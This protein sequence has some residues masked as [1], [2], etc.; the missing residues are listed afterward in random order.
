MNTYGI[1]EGNK[2]KVGKIKT[3]VDFN[4][5]PYWTFCIT[6]SKEKD[7]ST[8][9]IDYGHI[10]VNR[11]CDCEEGDYVIIKKIKGWKPAMSR[12]PNGTFRLYQNLYCDVEKC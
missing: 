6:I 5:K 12:L 9:V 1:F 11:M 4:K 8:Q 7:F 10:I 3:G 2:F